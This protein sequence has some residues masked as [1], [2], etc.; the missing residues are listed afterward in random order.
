VKINDFVGPVPSPGAFFN[1]LL[2]RADAVGIKHKHRWTQ[3]QKSFRAAKG[4]AKTD[5]RMSDLNHIGWD[6][7]CTRY[8]LCPSVV[9]HTVYK[10]VVLRH[11][12]LNVEC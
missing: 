9:I 2:T 12:A 3:M 8:Y 11:W 6:S 7:L 10:I 1:S 5:A 4:A